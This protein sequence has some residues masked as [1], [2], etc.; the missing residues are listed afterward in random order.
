[1]QLNPFARFFSVLVVFFSCLGGDFD[2]EHARMETL[3]GG[4]PESGTKTTIVFEAKVC[5]PAKHLEFV[6]VQAKQ[7]FYEVVPSYL[8]NGRDKA[9]FQKGERIYL[10][11]KGPTKLA[12]EL[13][14]ELVFPD[15]KA[16]AHIIFRKRGKLK[17][18]AIEKFDEKDVVQAP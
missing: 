1:M 5:K 13:E 14:K 11:T 2:V 12:K 16:E 10:V 15:V 9:D 3:M 17:V 8:P 4:R 6:A 7:Q 18:K